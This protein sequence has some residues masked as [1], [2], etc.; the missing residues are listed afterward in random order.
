MERYSHFVYRVNRRFH[1]DA[2][3][4]RLRVPLLPLN[5]VLQLGFAKLK[6]LANQED[7]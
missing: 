6:N 3:P 2:L 4:L 7:F 1:L 5:C